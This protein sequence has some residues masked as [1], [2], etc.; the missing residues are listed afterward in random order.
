MTR[1]RLYT[2]IA[3]QGSIDIG[4]S[5]EILADVVE[6]GEAFDEWSPTK[7]TMVC[8]CAATDVHRIQLLVNVV[9][10]IAFA[11]GNQ[12]DSILCFD[13]RPSQ[14]WIRCTTHYCDTLRRHEGDCHWQHAE[15]RYC[16]QQ[17]AAI[18]SVVQLQAQKYV[19]PCTLVAA[20]AAAAAILM[21]L[22]SRGN[23]FGHCP[24]GTQRVGAVCLQEAM[25]YVG[26][27]IYW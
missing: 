11:R 3:K 19:V 26:R 24:V 20:A 8:G 1:A 6:H 4:T 23:S 7:P 21:L 5:Q 9:Q 18:C 17:S 14:D 13:K 15:R 12:I 16:H 22:S 27:V 2:V 25:W 10:S